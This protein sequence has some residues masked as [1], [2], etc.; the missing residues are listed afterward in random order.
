MGKNIAIAVGALFALILL[1][2]VLGFFGTAID[3][4][5]FKFWAPKFENVKRE[6]FEQTQSYVEGKRQ[7]LSR[8]HHEWAM[9]KDPADKK[10]IES[11]IRQQFSNVKPERIEDAELREWM[12][13]CLNN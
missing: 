9:A 10:A 7:D 11:V 12:K 6:T 8:Y 3:F 2:G 13:S 5:S 4:A 1:G